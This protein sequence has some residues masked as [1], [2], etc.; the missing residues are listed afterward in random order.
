MKESPSE[1]PLPVKS[2]ATST[3][4]AILLGVASYSF[5]TQRNEVAARETK[6]RK[7]LE[8]LIATLEKKTE[9]LNSQLKQTTELIAALSSAIEP[10]Q[11]VQIVESLKKPTDEKSY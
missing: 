6:I 4:L 10:S 5:Q 1:K 7:E 11:L 8:T 2:V 3:I 9:F